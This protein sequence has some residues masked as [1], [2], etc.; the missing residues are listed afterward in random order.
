MIMKKID[1]YFEFVNHNKV[2]K[3]EDTAIDI[4]EGQTE[5]ITIEL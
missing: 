2:H 3:I 5:N 4:F 1:K